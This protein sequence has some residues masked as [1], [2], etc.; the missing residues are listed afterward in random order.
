M[1]N[2]ALLSL[3]PNDHDDEWRKRRDSETHWTKTGRFPESLLIKTLENSP[4]RSPSQCRAET[5]QRDEFIPGIRIEGAVGMYARHV[6]DSFVR[7]D[8]MHNGR[9]LY[10]SLSK[11]NHWLYYSSSKRWIVSS[12]MDDNLSGGY[13]CC[14]AK[15]KAFGLLNPSQ[16]R[17]WYVLGNKRVLVSQ[18]TV[19]A[20]AM[21]E[22]EVMENGRAMQ[23]ALPSIINFQ[24]AT[25]ELASKINGVYRWKITRGSAQIQHNFG[26]AMFY[27]LNPAKASAR[28]VLM[29][30]ATSR[31]SVVQGTQVLAYCELTGLSTPCDATRWFISNLAKSF[32]VQP[33]VTVTPFDGNKKRDCQADHQTVPSK[34][35]LG[36]RMMNP[37]DDEFRTQSANFQSNSTRGY[38]QTPKMSLRTLKAPQRRRANSVTIDS[39][40]IDQSISHLVRSSFSNDFEFDI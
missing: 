28:S 8:K 17:G 31:W 16:A 23:E 18:A 7:T 3:H 11:L 39:L 40:S 13:G 29:Y 34:Y 25:G 37:I 20:I 12:T 5:K 36:P 19:N 35:T 15:C 9:P 26:K 1:G 27:R 24:G 22:S 6:N 2:G 38:N 30:D 14:K 21:T 4:C 33:S 32:Y 10:R